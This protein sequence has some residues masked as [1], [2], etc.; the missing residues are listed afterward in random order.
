MRR[1]LPPLLSCQIQRQ[2]EPTAHARAAIAA[3]RRLLQSSPQG[4]NGANWRSPRQ[5][6]QAAYVRATAAR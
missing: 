4:T 1:H 6:E 2:K 3:T 5:R